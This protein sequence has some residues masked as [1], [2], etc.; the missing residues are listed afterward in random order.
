MS[1]KCERCGSNYCAS[2]FM[3]YRMGLVKLCAGC[4][5]N[6]YSM[7]IREEERFM[8]ELKNETN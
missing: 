1:E 3:N 4:L 6:Y 7:L 2:I 5:E 8:K